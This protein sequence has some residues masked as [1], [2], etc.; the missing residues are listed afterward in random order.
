ML[1]M[2]F[3]MTEKVG[4]PLCFC[5]KGHRLAAVSSAYGDRRTTRMTAVVRAADG[6]RTMNKSL[7]RICT[8][9]KKRLTKVRKDKRIL[10]YSLFKKAVWNIHLQVFTVSLR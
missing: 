10:A 7:K 4:R 2:P 8:F 3:S 1:L 5:C 9:A 6:R